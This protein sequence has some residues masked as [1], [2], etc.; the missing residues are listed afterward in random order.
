M[1]GILPESYADKA[2]GAVFL[3]FV[4]LD[5]CNALNSC[6]K[7]GKCNKYHGDGRKV[8]AFQNRIN[9]G[10]GAKVDHEGG[11]HM[12]ADKVYYGIELARFL[13]EHGVAPM[14]MAIMRSTPSAVRLL[15]RANAATITG[16]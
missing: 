9:R 2:C 14:E 11:Y 12:Y 15:P 13:R 16:G 7:N 5:V 8:N 10:N 3:V 1:A 6:R 4:H